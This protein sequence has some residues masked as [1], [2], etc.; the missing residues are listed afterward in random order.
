M[1]TSPSKIALIH[2]T[3]ATPGAIAIIQLVGD[4]LQPLLEGLT[5][6]HDW[7]IGRLRVVDFA[8][9]DQGLAMRLSNNIVQLMPHGGPRVVQRLTAKLVEL[10]AS[11]ESPDSVEPLQL[12]PEAQDRIEALMLL[13]LARAESPLAIDLLPA[14]PARWRAAESSGVQPTGDDLTRSETLSRLIHPPKVVLAGAPNVGKSTL[15]NA[16]LGR[17]I[18]IAADVPG[19][20][21][22]Y[23]AGRIDLGGLVVDWHDTPGL[24]ADA[25]DIERQAIDIAQRLISHADMLI[26]MRD[27]DHD[28]PAL[29]REPD[30]WVINK[31]DDARHIL[32]APDAT[33]GARSAEP[34]RISALTGAGLAA[35]SAAI[36]EQL[37]PASVISEPGLWLFDRRL[38]DR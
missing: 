15:S 14:Q 38:T 1:V 10:G 19:T 5:G 29:P 21:R 23:V 25:D 30:L 8:G 12:Y 7:P 34:L 13:T 20:T 6:V 17:T 4:D 37:V 36:R 26:A 33:P 16:L 31:V 3:A 2:A 22:D 9:I 24:R 27:A 35:L 11:V 28:W 18:S 32:Q